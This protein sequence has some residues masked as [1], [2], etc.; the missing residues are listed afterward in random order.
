MRTTCILLAVAGLT[1]SCLH[2]AEPLRITDPKDR[3][4]VQAF[5]QHAARVP[6]QINPEYCRK[7]AAE[8]PRGYAWKILPGLEMLLTAYQIAG[9]QKYLEMF[10]G[11]FA[12]MRAAM[13]SGADGYLG[14]Y[15]KALPFVRNPEDPDKKIDVL[16]SSFRTVAVLSRF[17]EVI[18]QDDALSTSFANHRAEYLDLMENHL[19]KKWDARGNYVDLGK[20]GA[21]YRAHGGLKD[22]KSNLTLPHN[23]HSI[24]L[25]GLLGLHRVSG[26]DE[27]AKKAVKLGTRF[28]HCLTL[29][30]GHYEWNYWDPAGAWD[31]HP[32]DRSRW[33]HWIGP[34][35]R[36]NYYSLSLR[37]AVIL[38]HHG[39]VFDQTD[40]TR[41]L[42]TQSKMTWGELDDPRWFRSKGKQPGLYVC[43]ELAPFDEKIYTFL[44]TGEH[45]DERVQ[46]AGHS[47][48]GGPVAS[49]WICGKFIYCPAATTGKQ[50]HLPAGTEFLKK[51]ENRQFLNT[52]QFEVA[53]TG[54]QPP[55]SPADMKPTPSRP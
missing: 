42:N 26:N 13:S 10:A 20:T 31:I 3:E 33:K 6:E 15:G 52:L 2:G 28:K 30:D 19:V 50:V 39:L 48:Q 11:T 54:Y 17:L 18:A 23:M 4:I 37:Q 7:M 32:E 45:Q 44:Y 22:V 8:E 46:G 38:Y 14:W 16:V 47:W 34:E 53:A 36:S 51:P 55:W 40:L 5:L 41:L 29:K 9:D 21:I 49:D 12:N 43:S 1:A 24:I 35:H 25:R 27:Y